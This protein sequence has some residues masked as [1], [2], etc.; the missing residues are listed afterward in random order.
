MP[1]DLEK[2]GCHAYVLLAREVNAAHACAMR[3]DAWQPEDGAGELHECGSMR[4]A[5]GGE[6][7]EFLVQGIQAVLPASE[8][9]GTRM[10]QYSQ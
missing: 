5:W 8:R 4:D 9:T 1:R 3:I 2:V 10:T 7:N 6:K